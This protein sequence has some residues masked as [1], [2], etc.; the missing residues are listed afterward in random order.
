MKHSPTFDQIDALYMFARANGRCWK[1]ALAVLWQNGAYNNAVLGGADPALLQQ[2]RNSFGPSWLVKFSLKRANVSAAV[3]EFTAGD[4]TG[5]D[6]PI[7]RELAAANAACADCGS[8]GHST[9]SNTCGG[10]DQQDR[11]GVA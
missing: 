8:T 10:P 2:V 11:L 4:V 6:T 5:A 1:S 7:G 3:R 9:G